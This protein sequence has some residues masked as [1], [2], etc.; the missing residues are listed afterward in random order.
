MYDQPRENGSERERLS[1]MEGTDKQL[2][3]R[4]RKGDADA[5]ETLVK[6]YQSTVFGYIVNMTEG[7]DDADEIFQEVW[8][9]VI[10]KQANYKHGNFGGWLVR[11]ARN[12]IIDRVRRRKPE[13]SLDAV[14]EDGR[15][16]EETLPGK[17]MP[18]TENLQDQELGERIRR[19]VATLPDDQKDVFMMR[20]QAQLPFKEIADIQCVSINT[21]LARMQYAL[22]KLRDVLK[23]DYQQLG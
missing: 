10:R 7:R 11:I 12:I 17:A 20:I 4:Y 5:L 2:L 23:D 15:S 6:R 9:R 18:P 8:F 22:S 21:A 19:A 13:I 1:G 16:L 3:T 14:P